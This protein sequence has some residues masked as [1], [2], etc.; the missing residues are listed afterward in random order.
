VSDDVIAPGK[1]LHKPLV[2][3][4]T[5]NVLLPAG[6]VLTASYIERL[7]RQGLD[8]FLAECLEVPAPGAAAGA[9]PAVR[10][11]DAFEI[12]IPA[13][14]DILLEFTR[15]AAPPPPPAV[16]PPAAA[17]AP[18]YVAPAPPPA[19]A[20]GQP[21]APGVPAPAGMPAYVPAGAPAVPPAPPP[22]PVAPIAPAQR[23][24]HNPQHM[25]PERSLMGAMLAVDTLDQTIREGK[26]PGAEAVTRVVQ[27][28]ID[29]L[30]SNQAML[31][32]GMELRIANQPHHRSH[33][34]NVFTL[35]VAMG[36]A[37]GYDQP[38]LLTLGIAA[39][40]HDIGKTAI[41]SEVLDKVGPLAP[42]E[43]D[44]LRAHTLMGKRIME[45]LPWASPDMAR[46]V[47][48]HHERVDGTGYPL[49]LDGGRIH[50]MSR[51]VAVAEVY[52]A[53][54]SDTSY[55]PRYSA[56]LSYNTIRNGEKM[57][58]DPMVLR[59][60]VRFVF[61]YPMNSFVTLDTGEVA[62]V[63]T[64]NRQDPLRP[65]VKTGARTINLLEQPD[66]KIVNSHFQGF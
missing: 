6:T 44:L 11:L 16:T 36:L 3:P 62:Q 61:P 2:H 43:I 9:T 54:V 53:L 5:G 27:E 56:E 34:V 45:K 49:R 13:L 24:Y 55:R 35:S 40:C 17:G 52:D 28:V 51:I 39:L 37:L 7:T 22:P 64:N 12:E 58:L 19:W 48:E 23:Y 63:V 33:P 21:A 32:N 4:T 42:Q 15:P 57:G 18:G 25:L 60:F 66:R 8:Q 1:K 10:D 59:A 50:E 65:V 20:A 47:Y 26:L 31:G 41:P 30:G 29:R 14:P 46:I 38:K